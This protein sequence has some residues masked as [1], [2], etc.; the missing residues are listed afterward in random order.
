[1]EVLDANQARLIPSVPT[2][3]NLLNVRDLTV[4]FRLDRERESNVLKQVSFAIGRS[5]IVG[6]LGESGSGK[7][8]MAL[9]SM[10]LL[11]ENASLRAGSLSF[12][13]QD[14][15]TLT[16]REMRNVRGL[17]ISIIH[18]DSDVLNPVLRAG[19]Q[20]MEVLRTHRPAKAA[21]M[22]DEI[23]CLFAA[24][25][26][27]DCDRVYRA[28]PHQ[29]SGGERRRVAIA[30]AL[31]CKPHLVI[32]DEPTAWLDAGTT[33]EILSVFRQLREMYDTAFLLIS[34]D[35]SALAIADRILVM[36][37]G[38]IV[39]DGPSRE[40]LEQ[41]R[42]PYTCALL[43]CRTQRGT[44]RQITTKPRS[45]PYIPGN[46]PDPSETPAGCA[47]SCRCTDRME[48]C[49]QRHPEL[50]AISS[51][52]SVRCLQYEARS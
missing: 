42:Q 38:E 39:E 25:G 23:Y 12:R 13:G 26:L 4:H 48:V 35:P 51:S 8:T 17:K 16:E 44:S 22:R 34:H 21:Q 37:A 19:H 14:L 36:Y 27:S 3:G 18:Q 50:Y 7:T 41:P 33:S 45:L 32:A 47:F 6:L 24:L 29:L 11:P 9:S 43:Q 1:M 20:V 40:I 15:L 2:R 52:R 49:D 30:Q 46:A 5:E 28:F 10:R 31:V